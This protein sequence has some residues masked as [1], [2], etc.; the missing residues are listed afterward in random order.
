MSMTLSA[1]SREVIEYK[2]SA[3]TT[4]FVT[5]LRLGVTAKGLP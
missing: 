5:V 4:I 1:A 2:G 3:A